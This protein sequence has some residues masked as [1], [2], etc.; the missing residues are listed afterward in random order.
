MQF[1]FWLTPIV[2][3][4]TILPDSLRP[5]MA[6]NPMANLMSAYQ[7]VLVKGQWPEW[8]SLWF[9]SLLAVFFCL[10]GLRL[11]RNHSGEM[12]DEL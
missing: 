9:V 7:I 10:T 2:Y 12:V 1:W 6:L 4:V 11:F 3:S 8:R 5:F